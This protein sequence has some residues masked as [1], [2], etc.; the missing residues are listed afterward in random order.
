M[1][2]NTNL[3]DSRKPDEHFE[4]EPTGNGRVWRRINGHWATGVQESPSVFAVDAEEE[5]K[6]ESDW[7]EFPWEQPPNESSEEHDE[8][9]PPQPKRRAVIR[10]DEDEDGPSPY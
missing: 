8:N 9:A 2:E 1:R 4:G 5:S 6:P 10:H 3:S 7:Q